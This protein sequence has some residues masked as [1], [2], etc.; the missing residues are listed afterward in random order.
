V[1]TNGPGT[2]HAKDGGARPRKGKTERGAPQGQPGGGGGLFAVRRKK[3]LKWGPVPRMIPRKKSC[4]RQKAP[5]GKENWGKG[6]SGKRV[7][8]GKIGWRGGHNCTSGWWSDER[9]KLR[10]GWSGQGGTERR[11][12]TTGGL[13]GGGENSGT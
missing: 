9:F 12:K 7:G 10:G 5:W 8:G 2:V 6:D 13:Q 3:H 4:I 1:E 11:K